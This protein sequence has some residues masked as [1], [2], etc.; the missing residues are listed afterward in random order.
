MINKVANFCAL[1]FDAK[2]NMMDNTIELCRA[3][4]HE[5]CKTSSPSRQ[6]LI[7]AEFEGIQHQ[8]KMVIR[9]GYNT[10]KTLEMFLRIDNFLTPKKCNAPARKSI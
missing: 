4:Y 2:L 8:I 10:N 3:R 6:S 7:R 5:L 9:S 1:S